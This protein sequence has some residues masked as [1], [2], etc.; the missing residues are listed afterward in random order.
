MTSHP[1]MRGCRLIRGI[2]SARKIWNWG[3]HW[4]RDIDPTYTIILTNLHTIPKIVSRIPIY[5]VPIFMKDHK[6]FSGFYYSCAHATCIERDTPVL[7]FHVDPL[8]LEQLAARF[9][10]PKLGLTESPQLSPLR[11]KAATKLKESIQKW[12]MCLYVNKF[13]GTDDD[14]KWLK[15]GINSV[16][17]LPDGA[18]NT[19]SLCKKKISQFLVPWTHK[20]S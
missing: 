12:V 9:L 15:F 18:T 20:S 16:W 4:G 1:C 14:G 17:Q 19:H 13:A 8:C 6:S 7:F 2:P 10:R 11:T 3:R 5:N